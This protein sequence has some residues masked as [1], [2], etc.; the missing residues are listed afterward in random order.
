MKK[1]KMLIAVLCM[2]IMVFGVVTSAS[3]LYITY[4]DAVLSG[5]DTSQS[6]IDA[7][8]LPY[9]AP[10]VEL[11]KADPKD[12]ETGSLA[13]SYHTVFVPA[14]DP[15][16]AEIS[17]VGGDIVGPTAYLLAKDGAALPQGDPYYAWYLFDLTALGW[18][19]TE[20]ITI[21]GLWPV[22]GSFSHVTLYG[23]STSVP[24]P[25]TLLLLGLGLVGVAGIRRKLQ[26]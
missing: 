5:E 15:L 2:M 13:G 24:E 12:G 14:T 11:Y 3:A 25:T 6:A 7:I 23:T 4:T 18:S 1:M 22:T 21:T 19:G 20:T 26:K 8:I 10:A 16:T 17:Y 9:I